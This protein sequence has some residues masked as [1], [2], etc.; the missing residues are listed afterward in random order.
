M[1]KILLNGVWDFEV[2]NAKVG[3][4][5]GFQSRE[6]FC[7]KISQSDEENYNFRVGAVVNY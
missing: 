4:E 3:L 5:G 1:K 2:D 7:E 6:S